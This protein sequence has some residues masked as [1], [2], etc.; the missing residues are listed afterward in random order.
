[1]DGGLLKD[2][3]GNIVVTKLDEETLKKIAE[4]GNGAYIHAGNTEFGLNPIID[5]I[6]RIQQEEFQSMVFE[7]Y[8]EQY[9]YFFAIALILFIVEMLVG[10]R[11]A[12][13]HIFSK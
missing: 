3:Q 13:R 11:K 5:D 12:K 10:A 9:M 8:D 4:A 1:M 7:E 2:A 6:R